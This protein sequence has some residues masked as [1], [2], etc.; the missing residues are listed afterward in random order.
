MLLVGNFYFRYR[1]AEAQQL[2][3]AYSSVPAV[4]RHVSCDVSNMEP[5]IGTRHHKI[6]HNYDLCHAE[7]KKLCEQDKQQYVS[8]Q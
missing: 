2:A 6:G 3:A 8:P 7:F 1:A 5:I 4:H